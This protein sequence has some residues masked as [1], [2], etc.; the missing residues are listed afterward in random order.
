MPLGLEGVVTART[1]HDVRVLL[2]VHGGRGNT[3]TVAESGGWPA[4]RRR[5]W[6]WFTGVPEPLSWPSAQTGAAR[7]PRAPTTSS[8]RLSADDVLHARFQATKF[9]EG[10][11]QTEVDDFLDRV[12][13]ALRH[14]RAERLPLSWQEVAAARFSATKFREGY[15]GADVDA[16]LER[17]VTEL[18][19]RER[20]H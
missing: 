9:R 15:D 16:F 19:L 10:Y 18:R 11:D 20:G 6:R 2:S 13:A 4:F 17:I 14:D 8:G 7:D 3:V 12:T 1:R 5:A